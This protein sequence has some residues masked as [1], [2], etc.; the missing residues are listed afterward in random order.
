MIRWSGPALLIAA[1]LLLRVLG[2]RWWLLLPLLYGPRWPLAV[3]LLTPLLGH[4]RRGA[5]R[6]LTALTT[7]IAALLLVIDV[8]IPW[9]RLIPAGSD[10]MQRVTVVTW[11][12]QGGGPNHQQTVAAL[13]EWSPDVM[14]IAECSAELAVALKELVTRELHRSSDLCFVTKAP[15]TEWGPRDPR[16]FWELAGSGAIGR[17]A[18]DFNGTEVLVGGVHLETPREALEELGFLALRSFRATAIDNQ[19]LRDLESSVARNWIAPADE[20]R[21]VIIAGDFNLPV[22]SAIYRRWWGDLTNAFSARGAGLGWTKRTR[23]FGVRI[24]HVVVGNGIRVRRVAL[25]PAMGSDHR[26]VIVDL[27]IPAS[28]NEQ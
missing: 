21:P 8:R 6:T 14:V 22:E 13:L 10:A 5:R 27:M 18:I 7:G 16:D 12:A 1:L 15:V 25:G 3:L 4:R 11:N 20:L 28:I 23:W 19:A 9:R 26:P 17:M 2:D 24:D